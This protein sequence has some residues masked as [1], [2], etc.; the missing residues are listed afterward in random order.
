MT[1][2][3]YGLIHLYSHTGVHFVILFCL[4]SI[5]NLKMKN[6]LRKVEDVSLYYFILIFLYMYIYP[7]YLTCVHVCVLLSL[8]PIHV[9][10]ARGED[11]Q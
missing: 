1:C 3:V 9:L 6:D 5:E 2:V 8:V 11:H 10:T 7:S 4:L